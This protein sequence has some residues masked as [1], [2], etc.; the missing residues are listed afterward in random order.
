VSPTITAPATE[1]QSWAKLPE[2]LTER[3]VS[4]WLGIS[5]PTLSRLRRDA[6]GPGFIRLSTR[7]IGYRRS[8]IEA[9]LAEREQCRV[10]IE[11][12]S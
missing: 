12:S 2:V 10:A 9:W 6:T 1:P 3:E 4:E 11:P 5:Q 7:R 8:T